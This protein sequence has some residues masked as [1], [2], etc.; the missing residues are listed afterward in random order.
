MRKKMIEVA[1]PLD[2]INRESAREKSIRHGHPST[3]HLWWARRPLAACRAVLF[4]SLV[5]DPDSDPANWRSDGSVDLEK[6]QAR[7][8]ELFSLIEQLVKWE[9][10][11]DAELLNRARAE[12]A[13]SFVSRKVHDTKEW[14][15]DQAVC[16]EVA[17]RFLSRS[18]SNAAVSTLLAEHFPPMLDPF[19]G[20]GS[21]PLEA[22]RLGLRAYASDLNPVP[23]LI[24][25]ALIEIP[26]SFSGQPPVNPD[27]VH[28]PS[29]AASSRKPK[30]KTFEARSWRGAEGLAED[31]RYYGQWLRDQAHHR[32]GHAYPKIT[33]TNELAERYRHLQ[34][35]EG[36]ELT[37]IAWIWARTVASPDPAAN[38]A[39]VPLVKSFSL[40]TRAKRHVHVEPVIDRAANSYRFDICTD[41]KSPP[42]QGTVSRKGGRCLLTDTP[43]PFE[44]IRNAGKAGL[45]GCRMMAIVAEGDKGRV[46]L[47][48]IESQEQALSSLPP[49][50]T[51]CDQEMANNPFSLR[52]PLYGLTTFDSIFSPR[53]LAAL[54]VFSDLIP[55]VHSRIVADAG[56]TSASNR[57]ALAA[58]EQT[59]YANAI[60]TYLAFAL[61][62]GANYWSSMCAWSTSTEKMVSTFGRQAI[63]MVW[64]FAEANPFSDSSGNFLLGVDQAAKCVANSPAGVPGRCRQHDAATE[65]GQ[66]T[67]LVIATDP[68]YYNNI[69]YADLSD[70]FYL[71]LRRSLRHIYPD[72]FATVVVPKKD[73][74]VA[75]PYRFDGN[76]KAANDF[77]ESSLGR[78]FQQ[79]RSAICQEYPLTVFYA[80][81]QIEAVQEAGDE[82]EDDEA[83]ASADVAGAASTGWETMLEGL[84]QAGFAITGTWPMRTEL[85]GNL[86]KHMNALAS[87]VLLVAK[88]R[89]SDAPK[90]TRKEFVSQLRKEL[91]AALRDLQ[92]GN[93]AP[94]DLAQAA[95]GPGMAVYSR[96]SKVLES[97]GERL[98]VR[99]ALALIN[100]VLDEVL[101]EQEGDYD[102]DTRWSLKW[103]EQ[104]AHEDGPF[105]DANTLATA[106]SIGI[107]GLVETGIV[108]AKAGKVR[109]LVRTELMGGHPETWDPAADTDIVHW[110]VCQYIIHALDTKGE[111]GAA[112]LLQ[113]INAC[114]PGAAET[115]RE[116]AYRLYTVCERKKWAQEAMAYNSLIVAW[117]EIVKL[118]QSSGSSGVEAQ[119]TMF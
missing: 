113:R 39:H 84:I 55:E 75:S 17:S 83:V 119:T 27:A 116:L 34:P 111:A 72:L 97:S 82:G 61:D 5:D 70:F 28:D 104:F 14:S 103:F 68:P 62:K 31:I 108:Q 49:Q 67:T 74:I 1:I 110:E 107:N 18:A 106:M 2:A 58:C 15:V 50:V 48:P 89:A 78:A 19:C 63:P 25:K 59:E 76:R 118:A 10:S 35:H 32:L 47:P 52:P 16:G 23:V 65:Y 6:S 81:K 13:A 96:Y 42:T 112:A 92:Q 21:I 102:A 43:I 38:G 29:V 77:F 24:N 53:Q 91:P 86:K 54:T 40:S 93:I 101:A 98:T 79:M 66:Q 8:H 57:G 105:G 99:T 60:C 73:E 7:R 45:M 22:Q 80:F 85:P 4:A 114:Y 26:A 33:V 88:V 95:I 46:Y 69:D 30:Q 56:R 51:A 87:S 3:L 20:G 36:K 71:W 44:Y 9:N 109:L 100:Q 41:S 94:V 11:N 90:A 64:D 12:I 37:V 117:P 115:A